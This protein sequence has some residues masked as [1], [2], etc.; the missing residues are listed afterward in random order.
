M[1]SGCSISGVGEG[2]DVLAARYAPPGGLNFHFAEVAT[3][4]AH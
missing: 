4:A 2:V 3:A 1:F